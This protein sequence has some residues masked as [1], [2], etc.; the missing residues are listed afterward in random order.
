MPTAC[1]P[2]PLEFAP[3]AG[4]TVIAGF[5]GG[6]ITS[7][8]VDRIRAHYPWPNRLRRRAPGV[9]CRSRA[10]PPVPAPASFTRHTSFGTGPHF[11]AP[12]GQ[13]PTGV[14]T[15]GSAPTGL[16][17]LVG[18]RGARQRRRVMD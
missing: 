9:R 8:I 1:N 4:H 16:Q 18:E 6:A 17:A 10:S 5:S 12:A 3:V 15:Q 7:N 14:A 2:T 11:P 13:E